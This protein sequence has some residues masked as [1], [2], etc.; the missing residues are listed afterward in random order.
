MPMRTDCMEYET[1]RY[2]TGDTVQKCNLDLAPDAPWRCPADCPK[3][4]RR[5]NDAGWVY[6]S[7]A[8][9][10]HTAE[11]AGL[12]DGSAAALLDEAEEIIN[13]AG[14]AVLADVERERTRASVPKWQFW[15]RR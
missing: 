14:P 8:A 9:P 15:R 6:G 13:A 10:I 11:P 3:Y 12:D 1:R 2:P 5:G 4:A 7:L